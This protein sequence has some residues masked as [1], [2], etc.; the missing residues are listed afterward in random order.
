MKMSMVG[1][2]TSYAEKKN[3]TTQFNKIGGLTITD[4]AKALQHR[5]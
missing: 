1:N 2:Q 4:F 5:N 3:S